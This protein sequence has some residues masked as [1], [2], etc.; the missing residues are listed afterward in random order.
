[1]GTV[2]GS[3]KSGKRWRERL[4][5]IRAPTLVLHGADD[6]FFPLGN[7]E[8][9]AREIPGAELVVL[10]GA[11]QVLQAPDWDRV[12]D[13]MLRQAAPGTTRPDS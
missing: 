9:L 2:F 8:A 6:P 1:M 12:A 4:G 3:L 13:A 5:E 10:P 7:G 11:G